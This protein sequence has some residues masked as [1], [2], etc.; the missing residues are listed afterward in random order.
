[1]STPTDLSLQFLDRFCRG[2]V[3][4]LEAILDEDLRFSGP[5]LR[6]DSRSAYLA[7]LRADPP[8]AGASY[9]LISLLEHGDEATLFYE[10]AAG[11]GST[12]IAQLNRCGDGRIREILLV[13][14]ARP[15][16]PVEA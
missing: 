6:C 2:D 14:D 8:E 15:P 9:S 16:G 13:F 1:M 10:Y 4:G 7:S 5:L 12:V 3:D 11:G